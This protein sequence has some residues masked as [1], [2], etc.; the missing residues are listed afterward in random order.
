MAKKYIIDLTEVERE[1]LIELTRKGKPGARKVKRA[2]ILLLA[3]QGKNDEEIVALLHTSPS[4]V[5]RTRR[6]FVESGLTFALNERSRAGRLPKID[7][8]VET[9]LTTLAQS[10]PPAGRKRWTLQLLADRLVTLTHLESLSY[11]SVRLVL[12]KNDLKPW[13][14]QKWCIPTVIGAEF[15]WLME[16]ILDLYAESYRGDYPVIC[17][18]EV[19]YQLVS[20]TRKPLPPQ[21]GKPA[22][23]DY[24]YRREGTCNLF[25]FLE[26]LAGW[27]HVKVTDR[28]TKQD[29]AVC[30][31]E[32]I[33]VH[34]PG[35]QK[36]RVVLDNL[37]T[38]TPASL[39]ERYPPA[40]ARHLVQ[41]LEFHHTPKHSSWLNMAEVEIS[42]L[43]GQCLDRRIG[44][45]KKLESEIA[46]WENDRNTGKATIDWRFTI[47]NARDKLVKL[48]PV[49]DDNR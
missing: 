44:S 14:R 3:N 33:E 29:F 31:N 19:P 8:K 11:E 49:S 24:E 7:D 26:P 15:V 34:R 25:M 2:N 41:K 10:R 30:M 12:K 4:T 37:N 40:K 42:V 6:K 23:Y 38:H 5:M 48:Y 47:P 21:P 22:R 43:N 13:V 1:T 45:R 32:L 18:D 35:S 17:F 39:Y 27:R 9:I 28:R 20:E 46:A 16:D 36:V